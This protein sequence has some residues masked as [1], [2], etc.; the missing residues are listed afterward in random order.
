LLIADDLRNAGRQHLATLTEGDSTVTIPVGRLALTALFLIPLFALLS[1]A[2]IVV[3]LAVPHPPVNGIVV[4]IALVMVG[5][6]IPGVLGASVSWVLAGA[7]QHLW[8]KRP[9]GRLRA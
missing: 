5:I 1:A 8:S 6:M 4:P 7:V 9:M 2:S 3:S